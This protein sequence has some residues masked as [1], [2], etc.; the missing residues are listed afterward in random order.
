MARRRQEIHIRRRSEGTLDCA[1][2][3]SALVAD[4]V[5][6]VGINHIRRRSTAVGSRQHTEGL[7]SQR[8]ITATR[9]TKT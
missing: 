6:V 1:Y 9:P 8:A 3:R 4:A 5:F 7:L 2:P